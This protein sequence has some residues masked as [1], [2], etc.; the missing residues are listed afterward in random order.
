M[1]TTTV[2]LAESNAYAKDR[3]PRNEPEICL[4]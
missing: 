2:G 4:I 3:K 1:G